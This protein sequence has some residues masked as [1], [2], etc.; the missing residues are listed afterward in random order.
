MQMNVKAIHHW[1]TLKTVLMVEKTITNADEALSIESL[2][3]NLPTKVMDQ[4]LRLILAYL[5]SKGDISIGEKGIVWIKND[6]P[7][8]LKMIKKSSGIEL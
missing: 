7:E 5:E 6:N 2:K 4:T 8:F 3:R 1:P